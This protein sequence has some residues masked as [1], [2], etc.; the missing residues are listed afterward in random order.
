MIEVFLV[1]LNLL[2]VSILDVVILRSTL[3]LSASL[4]TTI[5]LVGT[6]LCTLSTLVHLL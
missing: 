2:E 3:L 5:K 4:L 1:L 6:W